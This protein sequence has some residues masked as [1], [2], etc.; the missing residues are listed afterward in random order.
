MFDLPYCHRSAIDSE[1]L[2]KGFLRKTGCFTNSLYSV[3]EAGRKECGVVIKQKRYVDIKRFGEL[4]G[5]CVIN[6]LFTCFVVLQLSHGDAGKLTQAATA[7]IPQFP[8][9]T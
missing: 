2:G 4:F 7:H 1:P 6:V 3:S 8:I 5:D 9:V